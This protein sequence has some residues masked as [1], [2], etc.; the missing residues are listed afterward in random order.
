MNLRSF[1]QAMGRAPMRVPYARL[2][3]ATPTPLPPEALYHFWHPEREGVEPCPDWFVDRLASVH[4]DLRVVRPPANAPLASHAWLVWFKQPR[5]T[6]WLSPGWQ[7]LFVWQQRE[8]IDGQT[9]L[10]PLPLDERVLANL[11]G[12]SAM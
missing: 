1:Q 6:H 5:I 2:Q 11:Y 8:E 12:I 10:T 7:L 9:R 3:P 4:R